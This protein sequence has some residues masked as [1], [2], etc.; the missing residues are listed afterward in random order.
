MLTPINFNDHTSI[1]TGEIDHIGPERMLATETGAVKLLATQPVPQGAFGIGRC[2]AQL[3]REVALIGGDSLHGLRFTPTPTLPLAGGG[4]NTRR[5]LPL[6]GGG[7]GWGLNVS[8]PQD[9][10]H[11]ITLPSRASISLT[12]SSGFF[13][14]ASTAL[15]VV[16][17]VSLTSP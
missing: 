12:P 8:L 6:A 17:M 2:T 11:L 4:G 5:S 14:L 1:D 3:S 15:V 10:D 16:R 7:L 9:L 13:V